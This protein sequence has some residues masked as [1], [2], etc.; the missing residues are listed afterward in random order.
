MRKSIVVLTAA[1]PLALAA[2][3]TSTPAA[4][5]PATVTTS[6]TPPTTVTTA[7]APAE[8]TTDKAACAATDFKAE[9][10]AQGRSIALLALTNNGTKECSVRGWAKFSFLAADNSSVAVRVGNVDQPGPGTK[11]VLKPGQSAFAGFKWASC[12]KGDE[13]CH[14]V[15]TV[16]VTPPGTGTPLVA[17]FIGFNGGNEKV[18]EL[19]LSSAQVGTLQPATQGVVA[20]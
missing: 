1:L 5:P 15:T 3:G 16:Q 19:A 14:V 4:A 6:A 18:N 9:L 2:C 13:S 7:A 10:T 12:D 11:I 17:D 8:A 20:W